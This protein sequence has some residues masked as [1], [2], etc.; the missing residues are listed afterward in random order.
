MSKTKCFIWH[1]LRFY[2][3][4]CDNSAELNISKFWHFSDYNVTSA[5][6]RI[7][8][9]TSRSCLPAPNGMENSKE[10][11]VENSPDLIHEHSKSSANP[12]YSNCRVGKAELI[13]A[14]C[15]SSWFV[16]GV[17]SPFPKTMCR[18]QFCTQHIWQR[19]QPND[20]PSPVKIFMNYSKSSRRNY[21]A[22][23]R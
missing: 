16:S 4:T 5:E 7:F 11:S 19:H 18:L 22:T 2:F 8:G 13:E 20:C 10:H 14:W 15:G 3:S 17:H 6:Q 1:K 9:K 12:T 23:S 21:E